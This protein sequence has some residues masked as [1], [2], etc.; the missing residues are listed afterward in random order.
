MTVVRYGS[1]P[2]GFVGLS[3]DA[4]P[5]AP[6]GS[7]FYET[8]TG[9]GYITDG[10]TWSIYR[11]G[12]SLP[13]AR[14]TITFTGAANLGG[15][16]AMLETVFTAQRITGPAQTAGFLE[17]IDGLPTT[18]QT[19]TSARWILMPRPGDGLITNVSNETISWGGVEAGHGPH[20]ESPMDPASP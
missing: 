14:K 7:N 17:T 9:V 11:A 16:V 2:L 10:A 20:C 12:G 3:G 15:V 6:A 1:V 13:R 18:P 8:D 4:K 5:T 19:F